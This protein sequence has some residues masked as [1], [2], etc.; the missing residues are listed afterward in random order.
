MAQQG[1]NPFAK[2]SKGAMGLGQLMPETAKELSL[3]IDKPKG[4]GSVWDPESNLDASARYLSRLY[5]MYEKTIANKEA[6]GS[7]KIKP[8]NLG[9]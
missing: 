8:A 3:D 1:F 5:S 2:S 9:Y 7:A 6:I 4:Q